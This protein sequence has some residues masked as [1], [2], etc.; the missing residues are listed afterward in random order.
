MLGSFF[1]GN[2]NVHDHIK[3]FRHLYCIFA[4]IVQCFIFAIFPSEIIDQKDLLLH[5]INHYTVEH[6]TVFWQI[7]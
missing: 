3:I 1:I 2:N 4:G 6:C 7:L 5:S